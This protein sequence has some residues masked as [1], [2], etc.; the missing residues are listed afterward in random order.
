MRHILH[1]NCSSRW[2][3]YRYPDTE[4]RVYC[5]NLLYVYMTSSSI[6]NTYG[7]LLCMCDV[8]TR[9]YES[10]YQQVWFQCPWSVNGK[11]QFCLLLLST[12]VTCTKNLCDVWA[13]AH[14]NSNKYQSGCSESQHMQSNQSTRSMWGSWMHAT[15]CSV[16]RIDIWV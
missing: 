8:H 4:P 10:T 16:V 11:D 14:W 9:L 3:L 1:H 2:F 15:Q 13:L 12:A 6:A 7:T 5:S